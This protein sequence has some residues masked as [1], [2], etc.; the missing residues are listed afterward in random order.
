MPTV[1]RGRV[2][3]LCAHAHTNTTSSSAQA[4]AEDSL[5][6][7]KKQREQ[8]E[9]L[10]KANEAVAGELGTELR[11]AS[12]KVT[13]VGGAVSAL[14]DQLDMYLGKVEIEK[15]A[16]E[17]LEA[18]IAASQAALVSESKVLGGVN[19]AA[20][21]EKQLD[22][23][24]KVLDNRLE[25]AL[26]RFNEALASNKEMR[27][28]ID[29]LRAERTV[30][31]TVYR[32]LERELAERKKGMAGLI[33]AA[34]QAYAGR[35]LALME[36]AKLQ[37]EANAERLLFDARLAAMD[38]EADAATAAAVA[39]DDAIRGSLTME[40][41]EALKAAL[42]G[43]QAELTALVAQARTHASRV[44]FFELAFNRMR[45]E[46]G[47][48]DVEEL[49]SVFSR[50][51][52]ANFALFSFVSDQQGEIAKL[53]DTMDRLR[54]Q[55]LTFEGGRRLLLGVGENGKETVRKGGPAAGSAMAAARAERT[56]AA[57][58]GAA[59]PSAP[60]R[61]ATL[62]ALTG[63]TDRITDRI[64]GGA[65]VM[66]GVRK[67]LAHA[68]TSSGADRQSGAESVLSDGGVSD[69]NMLA[70]LALLEQRAQALVSAF[71]GW[72][73]VAEAAGGRPSHVASEGAGPSSSPQRTLALAVLGDGPV[74]RMTAS[75]EP[76]VR[77]PLLS[78]SD[79][80][81]EDEAE[82][83]T[84]ALTSLARDRGAA[85]VDGDDE[86]E[87]YEHPLSMAEIKRQA[88]E[89]AQQFGR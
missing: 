9:R 55:A 83:A 75:A 3:L 64:A 73:R 54:E 2:I 38:S 63:A 10:T 80:A 52:D 35:D 65:G 71:A 17:G 48:D 43:H 30:F 61:A 5:S 20:A 70:V 39:A 76:R 34:N 13:P 81:V 44:E 29:T 60:A 45:E 22:R 84:A 50:N 79:F 27:G 42:S 88:L 82:G 7:I 46:S 25:K 51:E 58:T 85:G 49:V 6:A 8:I 47:I 62:A 66:T 86:D 69:G 41:E 56:A 40:E 15:R 67:A 89:R 32:K 28:T 12:R 11:F 33:E 74:S 87:V 36:A 23:Q 72:Q 37:R 1:A 57:A 31:E 26:V 68:V 16:V 24:V 21:A 14:H 59:S 19:A 53:E 78:V 77:P 4:Y 18:A